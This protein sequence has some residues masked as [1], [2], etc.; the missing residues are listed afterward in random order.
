MQIS[1]STSMITAL[2]HYGDKTDLSKCFELVKNAGFEAMDLSLMMYCDIGCGMTVG[3]HVEWANKT[4]EMADKYGIAINQTHGDAL[5]NMQWDDFEH[6]RQ[7][8][9]TERNICCLEASKILGAKWMVVHPMNL[10]HLEIYNVK[11]NKEAN[12]RYLEPI[13][14]HAKKIGIGVAVENMVD[15]RRNKRRYCGGDP[16]ELLDLVDTIND[17]SVGICV[18]TGHANQ[19]GLNAAELIRL[20]GSRL[21][22]THIDDNFADEDTHLVPF[23]GN[24]NWKEVSK[25][26]SEVGYDND[27]SFELCWPDIPLSATDSYLKFIHTLGQSIIDLK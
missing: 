18:D 4:R 3:D 19:A 15:H 10:A 11:E 27:F 6:V 22:A 26:L 21:K 13:I 9:F 16:Y 17:S 5:N 14:E 7:K 23:Y 25:A 24:I 2:S 20:V 8:G 1:S 12:L